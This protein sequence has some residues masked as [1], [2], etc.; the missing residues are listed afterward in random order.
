MNIKKLEK[1]N[2]KISVIQFGGGVFLRG[3]FDV[4]MQEEN[5]ITGN[6]AGDV[7]IVRSKTSG[8]DPLADQNFMYT[9]VARDGEHKVVTKVDC[10]A[11]S[12]NPSDDFEAFLRLADNPDTKTIVS[13]TTEA[14]IV[15]VFTPKPGSAESY[16]AR[17]AALIK[18]RFDAGLPGF[19]VLPCELIENN[20]SKLREIV[21]QHGR[22]WEFGEDFAAFVK[23]SCDFR[24]TLVDR[25][26]S[27]KPSPDD[28]LGLPWE[29]AH[30]NTSEYFRLWAIEGSPD[31]EHPLP[32]GDE[33]DFVKYVPALSV[34]RTMKVRI[35]NGAHTS[36]I[37]YALLSG[38]ETVGDCLADTKMRSFLDECIF[39]EILP[40]LEGECGMSEARG[41]AEDVIWRFANPFIHHKCASIA[42]NSVSKW[43]V[44]V[45]PSLLA[46][47]EKRG[48]Y[49][50]GL[51]FSLAKLIEMY[52]KQPPAD[53]AKVIKSMKSRSVAEILADRSLWG[54]DLSELLHEVERGIGSEFTKLG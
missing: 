37:P 53:D 44:R 30:V 26:V 49:P 1:P 32:F 19:L 33:H 31:P 5:Q 4:M 24:N 45:L 18:R 39:G 3:F 29:D 7:M 40:S 27:G 14:G 23:Y 17:L 38:L 9:H 52:K 34:F 21:L 42:L 2:R 15:Y 46:Y 12:L 47:K 13:N 41:Y 8:V 28:E 20:G 48:E 22:D 54:M 43:K 51:V 25:I 11:G 36:M 6:A 50:A 10:I 16:P 35:L